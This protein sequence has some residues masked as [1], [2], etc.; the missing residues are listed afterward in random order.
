MVSAASARRGAG[1]GNSRNAR[2]AARDRL[3]EAEI[4]GPARGPARVPR[5]RRSGA[6]SGPS[7]QLSWWM[8]EAPPPV[9][10]RPR[11]L[12]DQMST[13]IDKLQGDGGEAVAWWV[14]LGKEV[15]Q[16]V[17]CIRARFAAVTGPIIEKLE[18]SGWRLVDGVWAPDFDA[19]GVMPVQRLECAAS[20]KLSLEGFLPI[21][22][23]EVSAVG[24]GGGVPARGDV[25]EDITD[26]L[27]GGEARRQ[28][29]LLGSHAQGQGQGG[30][31]LGAAGSLQDLRARQE[32]LAQQVPADLPSVQELT[33]AR[34]LDEAERQILRGLP[35][36]PGIS[37]IRSPSGI[38]GLP[39][40]PGANLDLAQSGGLSFE[41][42]HSG[43]LRFLKKAPKTSLEFLDQYQEYAARIKPD[44]PELARHVT[45][46]VTWCT[47]Q[48]VNDR[49]L[50][51]MLE[52]DASMRRKW[53]RDG[54]VMSFDAP[55]LD[56]TLALA[57]ATEAV[58]QPQ[59]RSFTPGCGRGRG[60][61]VR[62]RGG[63]GAPG[64][65]V[66]QCYGFN[67]VGGCKYKQCRFEH[68][69]SKCNKPGH[70]RHQCK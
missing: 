44:H 62:S 61:G 51:V 29:Q 54:V 2:Q 40:L 3:R 12:V 42:D 19:S 28:E 63:D 32:Q 46:Y 23:P 64:S 20:V 17:S 39:A 52:V 69:C 21:L 48:F 67:S 59:P 58:A 15:D 43:L 35:A 14:L 30:Q 27:L 47:T 65:G 53:R 26:D 24:G 9:E 10:T 31:A 68:I 49:S 25:L 70:G 4:G 56:S 37:Q 55:V 16:A 33:A 5:Q 36:F 8:M 41:L 6:A 18:R 45:E 57:I 34:G 1:R 66:R 22:E 11:A 38:S 60:R 7:G 13:V 50:K